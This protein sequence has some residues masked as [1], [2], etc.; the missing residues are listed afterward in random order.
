MIDERKFMPFVREA[1]TDVVRLPKDEE[2]RLSRYLGRPVQ[3]RTTADL[4]KVYTDLMR[5]GIA[6]HIQK[7]IR[8][9]SPNGG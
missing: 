2:R 7:M 6:E 8:E 1:G 4:A 3:V 9:N 5:R